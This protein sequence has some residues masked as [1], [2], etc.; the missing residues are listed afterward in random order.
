MAEKTTPYVILGFLAQGTPLSG[1]DIRKLI[2]LTVGHF[3]N[4]S[5]GQLYPELQRLTK[6]GLVTAIVSTK[7]KRRRFAYRITASG[8]KALAAWLLKPPAAE[9]VRNELLLKVFFGHGSAR[10]ALLQ[11]LQTAA[12]RWEVGLGE[13]AAAQRRLLQEDAE[14][15][16]LV[17]FI[18]TVR[19]G[20]WVRAAR[21]KWAQE[22]VELLQLA[23]RR[24]NRA[25]ITRVAQLEG[26]LP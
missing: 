18:I 8:R 26:A 3:W 23:S 21:L 12:T 22:S 6:S 7:R 2:G 24:G 14:S 17:Y 11:H 20:R 1:Y 25:L 5:F 9:R 13:L 15:P 4:E 16:E 10:D 19:H